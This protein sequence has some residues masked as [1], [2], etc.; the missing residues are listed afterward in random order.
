MGLPSSE[1]VVGIKHRGWAYAKTTGQIEEGV[2]GL[3][4]V[5][6][7]SEKLREKGL[8]AVTA[9]SRSR[10]VLCHYGKAAQHVVNGLLNE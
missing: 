10:F 3:R 2:E 6:N 8:V 1:E 5:A 9:S 7:E 4:D